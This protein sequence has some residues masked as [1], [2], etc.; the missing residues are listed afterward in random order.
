M[1]NG[2]GTMEVVGTMAWPMVRHGWEW[3]HARQRFTC[4]VVETLDFARRILDGGGGGWWW[5]D[6]GGWWRR[7]A[8]I[9]S[10]AVEGEGLVGVREGGVRLGRLCGSGG[11]VGLS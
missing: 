8:A 9:E 3:R 10:V 11:G 7:D 6:G 5:A 4:P 2:K 1:A